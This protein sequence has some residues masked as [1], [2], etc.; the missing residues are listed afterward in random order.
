MNRGRKYHGCGEVF[1]VGKG[2]Q[3]H[4]PYIKMG[5]K[6]SEE[7]DDYFME[8]NQNIVRKRVGKNIKLQGTL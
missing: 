3:C 5:R 6:S 4:L 1:N 2:K 8:E 7:Q